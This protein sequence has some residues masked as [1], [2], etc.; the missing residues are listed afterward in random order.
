MIFVTKLAAVVVVEASK[1]TPKAVDPALSPPQPTVITIDGFL[2]STTRRNASL[3]FLL[4]QSG[5][6]NNLSLLRIRA[7]EGH[8]T[9]FEKKAKFLVN[10]LYQLCF[11][12]SWWDR[13]SGH[14]ANFGESNEMP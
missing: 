1:H 6:T 8:E 11:Q 7:R 4:W 10:V 13:I 14:K 3:Q 2:R 12:G 5:T 9:S